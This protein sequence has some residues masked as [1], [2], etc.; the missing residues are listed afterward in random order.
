MRPSIYKEGSLQK[1]KA[2]QYFV[3]CLVPEG[4]QLLLQS[5]NLSASVT[6]SH[7]ND[8]LPK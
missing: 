3:L 5:F 4:F 7:G 8:G 2:A 1:L 6:R